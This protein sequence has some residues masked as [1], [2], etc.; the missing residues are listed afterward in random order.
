MSPPAGVADGFD[1]GGDC[2][3]PGECGPE[4]VPATMI[5]VIDRTTPDRLPQLHPGSWIGGTFS[6]WI[7][8]PEKSRGWQV[9]ADVRENIEKSLATF[10]ENFT[11]LRQTL[12]SVVEQQ[13]VFLQFFA[14]FNVRENRHIS[15]D[16]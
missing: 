10:R 13:N 4:L 6:T 7:G 2:I 1:A 12:H 9:L 8:H 16:G 11:N 3:E 15:K 14:W 5:E